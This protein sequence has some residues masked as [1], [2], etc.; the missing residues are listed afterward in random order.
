MSPL[1]PIF[2]GANV[3]LD[4]CNEAR[5]EVR[6]WRVMRSEMSPSKGSTAHKP[7]VTAVKITIADV[8]IGFIRTSLT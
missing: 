4:T 1:T 6:P 7:H 2:I 3:P 5:E 8:K